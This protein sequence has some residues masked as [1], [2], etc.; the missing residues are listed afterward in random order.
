MGIEEGSGVMGGMCRVWGAGAAFQWFPVGVG[1]YAYW[2]RF[3]KA[4]ACSCMQP[5]R[6]KK[7]RMLYNGGGAGLRA[8][9]IRLWRNKINKK[10]LRLLAGQ[11]LR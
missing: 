9:R 7:L 10:L 6:V 5:G 4:S 3:G 1:K 11:L 8:R 2:S